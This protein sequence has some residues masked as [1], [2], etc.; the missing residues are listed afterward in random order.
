MRDSALVTSHPTCR[1]R[2]GDLASRGHAV[3]HKIANV[4]ASLPKSAH[5]GA[6]KALAQIWNAEDKRHALDAVKA[7][8]AAYAGKYPKAA[9]K[10]TD[11]IDQLLTLYEFPAKHWVH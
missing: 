5:P 3:G 6:K 11:D 10:I 8:D 4:L 2:E 1:L 9:A 7:F